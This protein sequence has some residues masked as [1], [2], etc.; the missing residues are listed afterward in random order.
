MPCP[1]CSGTMQ[2]LNAADPGRRVYWCQYCGTLLTL[3][4]GGG[5]PPSEAFRSH[6]APGLVR[7]LLATTPDATGER[8]LRQT[9][10]VLAAEDLA[11]LRQ[12]HELRVR[13]DTADQH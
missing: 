4:F 6:E 8:T 13:H 10:E 9:A 7:S 2:N 1:T 12:I 3:T 5:L 11:N